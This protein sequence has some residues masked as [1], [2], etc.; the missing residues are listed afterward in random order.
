VSGSPPCGQ[1]LP[2]QNLT[3]NSRRRQRYS[4]QAG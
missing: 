1:R 2:G 4:I 3:L